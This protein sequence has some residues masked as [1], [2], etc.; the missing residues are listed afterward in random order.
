MN[1]I[2]KIIVGG[3]FGCFIGGILGAAAGAALTG[4]FSMQSLLIGTV[5]GP[6]SVLVMVAVQAS[7]SE[8]R[9]K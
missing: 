9:T 4:S 3:L 1:R 5:A 2:H 8:Q 7:K 6:L